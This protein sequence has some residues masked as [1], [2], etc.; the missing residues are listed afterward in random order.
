MTVVN[1]FVRSL[2]CENVVGKNSSARVVM[3]LPF[4]DSIDVT[5]T[6]PLGKVIAGLS[7]HDL[8]KVKF[9]NDAAATYLLR[10]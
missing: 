2:N 6:P 5:T 8:S 1:A 4:E 10:L 3:G 9:G 7:E